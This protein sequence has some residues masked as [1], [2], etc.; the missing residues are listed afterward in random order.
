MKVTS[1]KIR[2]ADPKSRSLCLAD[3]LLDNLIYIRDIKFTLDAIYFPSRKDFENNQWYNLVEIQDSNLL[4][5][6]RQAIS[7]AY[8]KWIADSTVTMKMQ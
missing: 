4:W 3:I 2:E 7:A 5:G 1:I 8:D 6:I